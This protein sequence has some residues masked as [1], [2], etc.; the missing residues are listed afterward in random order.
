MVTLQKVRA[1]MQTCGVGGQPREANRWKCVM[2]AERARA[3]H[4]AY[5]YTSPSEHRLWEAPSIYGSTFRL[6]KK[7][8][9]TPD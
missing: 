9:V 5:T 8:M 2:R 1:A 3:G 7:G 6:W 4:V